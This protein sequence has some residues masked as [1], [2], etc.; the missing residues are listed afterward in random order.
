[1]STEATTTPATKRTLGVVFVTLF[2]DLVGFSVVFPLFPRMLE[3]YRVAANDAGGVFAWLDRFVVD[4]VGW[5]GGGDASHVHIAFFGGL[6]GS[7]YGLLQ[8][9]FAPVWGGLSDRIGRK[10][11][12]ALCVTGL[13]ASYAL[14]FFA[15]SFALFF[16]SRVLAGAMAGN[17]SVA[18]AAVA[19]V[20]SAENRSRGMA[21]IGIAF[22]LGFLLGPAIGG[23]LAQ[24]ELAGSADGRWFGLSPFSL[25]AAGSLVLALANLAFVLFVFDETRKPGDE[26]SDRPRRTINPFRLGEARAFP[27]AARG[28]TSYFVY[29]LLFSG[30]EF[31]LV[32]LAAERFGYG[33]GK[34]ALM[35]AFIGVVIAGVQGGFV[36]RRAHA[37]GEARLARAG[38][39]LTIPGLA[40]VGFAPNAWT[41]YAGLFVLTVGGACVMPCLTALVSLYTP[42]GHQGRILGIFRSM[43]SLARAIG[44]FAAG[45]LYWRCGATGA[46]AIGA[47]ALVIP[48][49]I[50]IRLPRP[51]TD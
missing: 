3:H 49:W 38:I 1:M 14:W 50:A 15:A 25:A 16:V 42:A 34:N 48:L 37:I 5:I 26:A 17:I 12:L 27:G 20:T 30:M 11:V 47:A 10:P 23:A 29:L 18:T 36:R 35:F 7:I 13:V 44:P 45:V 40:I 43:G 28:I 22:G 2:L 41:L 32:F 51:S 31:T 33:P 19:D 39:A 21:I 4:A 46:Y 24:W 8:Y 9:V 6:L